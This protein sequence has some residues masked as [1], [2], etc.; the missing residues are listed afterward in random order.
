MMVAFLFISTLVIVSQMGMFLSP[1]Y[2]LN[3]ITWNFFGSITV[4]AFVLFNIT[5][6]MALV[7]RY[8]FGRGLAHFLQVQ[9][10]LDECDFTP[11]YIERNSEAVEHP[12]EPEG[13][14]LPWDVEGKGVVK[15]LCLPLDKNHDGADN[16]SVHICFPPAA[17]INSTPSQRSF[18][19]SCSQG[20]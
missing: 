2:R 7:C 10:V 8:F 3:F 15:K 18:R 12:K 4:M 19:M 17:S 1:I 14:T 16:I 6:S 11:V 13:G 5:F 9:E 20:T